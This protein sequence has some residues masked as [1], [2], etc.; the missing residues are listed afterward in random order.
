MSSLETTPLARPQPLLPRDALASLREN[1]PVIAICLLFSL[2]PILVSHLFAI[3]AAPYTNLLRAYL[4]L[5]VYFAICLGFSGAAWGLYRLRVGSGAAPF[6]FRQRLL[7]AIPVLAFWPITI[8]SFSYL[9][10]VMPLVH[11]FEWDP[12]FHQLDLTLHFGA[13]PWEWLAPLLNHMP[14]TLLLSGG[15]LLWFL[16]VQMVLTAQCMSA[17]NPRLRMQFIL[18]QLLT[19]TLVGN[20]AATLLSSAGPCYYALVVGGDDPYAPLFAYLREA[21]AAMRFNLFGTMVDLPLSSLRL[22][23]MLWQSH[24]QGDFGFAKGISAAP[25]MHIASTWIVTRFC[26]AAGRRA[27]ILGSL[28]LLVIFLGSI[29]LGWH[30][31]VDGYIAVLLAWAIWRAVDWI[32][33]RPAVQRF[34]W[35]AGL[36]A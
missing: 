26:F 7:L 3:P 18:T 27:A 32:L 28:F 35:P 23:D 34:L 4:L 13:A 1:S 9:K 10:S 36:N 30:Y 5:G 12:F 2:S 21:S 19:W 33:G 14:V 25:S 11:P 31:A 16:V 22:Q 15:Y 24:V 6:R 20:L 29:H 8:S 17:R